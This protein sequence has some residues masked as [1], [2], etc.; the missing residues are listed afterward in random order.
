VYASLL[1]L[2]ADIIEIITTEQPPNMKSTTILS[3]AA[4]SALLC[5]TTSALAIQPTIISRRQALSSGAVGF[6]SAFFVPLA[7]NADIT[8]KVASSAQ[9]RNVK[10]ASKQLDTMELYA[11]NGDAAGLRSAIRLAPLSEVRKAAFTLVRGAEDGPDAELMSSTYQT[12]IRALEQMDS[13]AAVSV[14]GRALPEGQLYALYRDT[15]TALAEFL[16]IAD[17]AVTIPIQYAD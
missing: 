6:A 3:I 14:R 7:A 13:M 16:K 17:Q 5:K 10:R 15:V 4:L 8:S 2:P 11:T 9:L 12:F 1:C